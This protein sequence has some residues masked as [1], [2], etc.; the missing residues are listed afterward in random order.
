MSPIVYI[1]IGCVFGYLGFHEARSFQ[2]KNGRSPWGWDPLI[3]GVA[4][5]L[6]LL[7]GGILLLIARRTT[8]PPTQWGSPPQWDQPPSAGLPGQWGAPNE[9][10]PA[11]GPDL[12][13][14]P[15]HPYGA[16]T[17]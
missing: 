5:F 1:V 10:S 17:N 7:I 12:A 4:L 13:P 3:W 2:R 14:P 16:P 15:P 11:T 8:K 9:A 6:S